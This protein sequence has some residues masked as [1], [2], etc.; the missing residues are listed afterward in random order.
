MDQSNVVASG[1]KAEDGKGSN[2]FASSSEMSEVS[3]REHR[4]ASQD[5]PSI[6]FLCQGKSCLEFCG[7]DPDVLDSEDP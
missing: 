1:G 4:V 2:L 5:R 7:G 6:R 3:Q